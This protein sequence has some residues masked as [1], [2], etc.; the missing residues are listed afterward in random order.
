MSLR[1]H[2]GSAARWHAPDRYHVEV[3]PH[4]EELGSSQD[5]IQSEGNSEREMVDSKHFPR[6]C[7][8]FNR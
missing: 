6:N 3:E 5:W 1:M 2:S 8:G 4:G 7:F